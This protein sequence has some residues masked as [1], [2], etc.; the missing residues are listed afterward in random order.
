MAGPKLKYGLKLMNGWRRLRRKTPLTA[1]EFL[2]K[3]VLTWL[4]AR[5]R[6]TTQT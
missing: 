4:A 5:Y 2:L 1:A 6:I 3:E